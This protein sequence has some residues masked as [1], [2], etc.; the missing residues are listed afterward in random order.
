MRLKRIFGIRASKLLVSVMCFFMLFGVSGNLMLVSAANDHELCNPRVDE[1]G[2]ATW[3][4]VTFGSYYQDMTELEAERIKWR[5]LDIDAS[6]NA[7]LLADEVLECK[8][9]ND[10]SVGEKADRDGNLY[11]DYSCTWESSS[12][13]AWLNGIGDYKND[14]T[15]FFNTAFTKEEREAIIET[16]VT[17]TEVPAYYTSPDPTTYDKVYLLSAAEASNAAYG[18]D[19]EVSASSRTRQAKATDHAYMSGVYRSGLSDNYGSCIWW[20]RSFVG[21]MIDRTGIKGE[22]KVYNPGYGVDFKSFYGVRPALH[23]NLSSSFIEDAGK[24]TSNGD[25]IKNT[26]RSASEY[27]KPVKAAGGVTTWDC[28]Y[29][30]K[31]KQNVTYSK[32]PIE[33]RV[34]SVNGNDAFLLADMAIDSKPFNDK[35]MEGTDG[36]KHSDYACTWRTSPLRSWLNGTGDYAGNSQAFINAAFDADEKNAIISTTIDNIGYTTSDKVYLLSVEEITNGEYGFGKTHLKS[37]STRASLTTDYGYVKGATRVKD[38]GYA[39][40]CHWWLRTLGST[41]SSYVAYINFNGYVMDGGL[42]AEYDNYGVRPALHIDLSKKAVNTAG[43]INSYGK[44][45]ELTYL[46][47]LSKDTAADV[48]KLISSIGTVTGDSK[49]KIEAARKAYDA[50]SAGA[51]AR[52]TRLTELEGAEKE[53]ADIEKTAGNTYNNQ[54]NDNPTNNPSAPAANPSG[55]LSNP[56]GNVT[57]AGNDSSGDTKATDKTSAGNDKNNEAK[58]GDT[59]RDTSSSASYIITLAD[60][61]NAAVIYVSSQTTNVTNANVPDEVTLG[62]KKYKVTEIKANA[63]RNNRKLKK[64]T[65]GKNVKKI[66]KNAF[67]GCNNLKTITIKTTLLTKKSVGKNAFKGINAKAKIKVPKRKLKA[68]KSILKARGV[69]GKKQKITK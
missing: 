18:F 2:I 55:T 34:L 21:A 35:P 4:K 19:T 25:V 37:D 24:V 66:G 15:A 40:N 11:P 13:R 30:G 69:K 42:Y 20:L 38:S 68:Y 23:I 36:T 3:D 9:F 57:T 14:N 44:T 46:E 5:I 32:K 41:S 61:N 52:V 51:K 26:G 60:T 47:Q 27:S 22:G 56:T 58:V 31:Y 7:F 8:K 65:I 64:I 43:T 62:G 29:F 12:L 28:V 17:N 1:Y 33:W 10:K 49:S 48:D 59:I 39:G 16:T 63:F 54:G 6:G 45:T 67:Y 50:L 53:L